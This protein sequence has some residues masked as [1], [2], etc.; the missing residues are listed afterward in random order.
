MSGWLMGSTW[1]GNESN[2][3]VTMASRYEDGGFA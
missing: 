3:A 2:H 1:S